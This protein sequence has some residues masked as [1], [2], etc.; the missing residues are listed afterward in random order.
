[1]FI[2]QEIFKNYNSIE[3]HINILS[4]LKNISIIFS[5]NNYLKIKINKNCITQIQILIPLSIAK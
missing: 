3:M 1:M 5:F 2:G 4:L